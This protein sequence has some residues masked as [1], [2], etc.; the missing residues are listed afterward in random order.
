MT[1]FTYCCFQSLCS[2]SWQWQKHIISLPLINYYSKLIGFLTSLYSPL[3]FVLKPSGVCIWMVV[4]LITSMQHSSSSAPRGRTRQYTW[5]T[6]QHTLKQALTVHFELVT[7]AKVFNLPKNIWWAIK[8]NKKTKTTT[9]T[10]KQTDILGCSR[11]FA[12]ICFS[13]LPL[14]ETFKHTF[15]KKLRSLVIH[16]QSL[17]TVGFLL[18]NKKGGILVGPKNWG[19]IA[20]ETFIAKASSFC[21]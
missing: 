2:F 13:L 6:K 14:G 11:I 12:T 21:C 16:S 5:R 19:E 15:I 20:I 3:R 7:T 10:T 9:T 18:K 17:Y 1:G 4:L 8:K